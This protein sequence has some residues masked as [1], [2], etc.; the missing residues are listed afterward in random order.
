MHRL[1]PPCRTDVYKPLSRPEERHKRAAAEKVGSLHA[2]A[3]ERIARK[4][5]SYKKVTVG[6][7]EQRE[8]EYGHA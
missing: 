7:E 5:D 6:Y 4:S 3:A 1:Y 2:E 8:G